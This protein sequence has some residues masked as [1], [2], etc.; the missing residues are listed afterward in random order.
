MSWRRSQFG[1]VSEVS[2]TEQA[3]LAQAARDFYVDPQF[4]LCDVATPSEFDVHLLALLDAIEANHDDID[5][6]LDSLSA[7]LKN[8]NLVERFKDKQKLGLVYSSVAAALV[9]GKSTAGMRQLF[10][11]WRM[12]G[13]LGSGAAEVSKAPKSWIRPLINDSGR[14][15]Q[16]S[17]GQ[18]A[19]R[20][21]KFGR[22]AT[23]LI[24]GFT[25]SV[26]GAMIASAFSRNPFTIFEW[27]LG[28]FLGIVILYRT[29]LIRMK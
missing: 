1:G 13:R 9:K 29:P 21:A 18:P 12:V 22:T 17:G 6:R 10:A 23:S 3:W 8:S 15:P 20:V 27:G 19:R 25:F 28:I 5:A 4:R 7:Y 2:A 26:T 16:R 11:N 24:A 14:V